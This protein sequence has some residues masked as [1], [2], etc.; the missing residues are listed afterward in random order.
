M[1]CY[2]TLISIQLFY[3]NNNYLIRYCLINIS[4]LQIRKGAILAALMLR[5]NLRLVLELLHFCISLLQGGG[6]LT[7]AVN[8]QPKLF[9]Q[10]LNFNHMNRHIFRSAEARVVLEDSWLAEDPS[11]RTLCLVKIT[12][13]DFTPRVVPRLGTK[14]AS[15]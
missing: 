6:D 8:I 14:S 5:K 10:L 15:W 7:C 13:V 1:L 12:F 11:A 9:F 2:I 3:P 4:L